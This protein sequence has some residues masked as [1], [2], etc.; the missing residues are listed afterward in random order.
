MDSSK[1]Q[2]IQSDSE[3]KSS[4]IFYPFFWIWRKVCFRTPGASKSRAACA[5]EFTLALVLQLYDS[6]LD[7]YFLFFFFFSLRRSAALVLSSCPAN[8]VCN[9]R[10]AGSFL[11][12][13]TI[14]RVFPPCLVQSLNLLHFAWQIFY[15][16]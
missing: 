5:K 2:K 8:S 13:T 7:I 3:C 16:S 11:K 15:F 12:V 14:S 4:E 9:I 6:C 10:A 1:L